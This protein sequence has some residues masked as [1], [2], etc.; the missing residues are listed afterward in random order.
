MKGEIISS[1][2]KEW[3]DQVL[4]L[5][6]FSSMQMVSRRKEK[7]TLIILMHRLQFVLQTEFNT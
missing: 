5:A 6:L 2:A 4:P 1:A 7:T 3:G